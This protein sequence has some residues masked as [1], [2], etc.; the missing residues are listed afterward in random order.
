MRSARASQPQRS[1]ATPHPIKKR[2]AEARQIKATG[3][4]LE[5]FLDWTEVANIKL[6]EQEEMLS[7]AVGFVV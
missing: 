2:K 1:W 3:A 4:W 7:L 6:I 5:D